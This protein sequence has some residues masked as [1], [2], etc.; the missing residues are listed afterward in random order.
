[1]TVDT[2]VVAVPEQTKSTDFKKKLDHVF[3]MA[4]IA[5][6]LTSLV[7]NYHTI[8]RIYKSK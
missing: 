1:M 8:K 5:L 3:V 6:F 7:I 2:Q 4:G